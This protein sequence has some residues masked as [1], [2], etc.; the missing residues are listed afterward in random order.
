MNPHYLLQAQGLEVSIAGKSICKELNLRVGAGEV[1]GI[2]GQN[3]CGKT[4]LLHTLGGLRSA[5]QGQIYLALKNIKH[6]SAKE[7][8]RFLGL[9]FQENQAIFPQ[10]VSEYCLAGRYPH[11]LSFLETA[12]DRQAAAQALEIMELGACQEQNILTLSG[13][14]WRRLALA[15][16]LAQNPKLYL[17]DEPLNHLDLKHQRRLLQHFKLK[18]RQEKISV[19]M[20]L[21]DINIAEHYC[22]QLVLL[23]G[24][25]KVEVGPKAA[26]L[27]EAKVSALYGYPVHLYND[28][29][30]RW[31]GAQE[32]VLPLSEEVF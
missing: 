8:A 30:K 24:N 32:L 12:A 16:L 1:W 17:L 3:G 22:E 2:L 21:H 28:G 4:T 11:F 6:Y 10:K 23:Y 9:L 5:D 18:A 31:W 25:G 27:T 26:L 15:T 20:T 29:P 7:R 19:L 14:E 13:G